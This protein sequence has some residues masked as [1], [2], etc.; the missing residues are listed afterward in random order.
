[1]TEDAAGSGEAFFG[2]SSDERREGFEGGFVV[3]EEVGNEGH[4]KL[5]F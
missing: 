1:V 3:E 4:L 2:G 5:R